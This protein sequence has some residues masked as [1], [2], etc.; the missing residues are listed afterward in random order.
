MTVI[1]LIAELS[2][3]DENSTVMVTLNHANKKP[4][5][6]DEL[7]GVTSDGVLVFSRND[8]IIFS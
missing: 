1:E 5:R 7:L 8:S 4:A 6:S 3:L 2:K